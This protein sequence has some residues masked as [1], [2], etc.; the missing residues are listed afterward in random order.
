M[1]AET[2]LLLD[3]IRGLRLE[4]AKALDALRDTTTCTRE[5]VARLEVRVEALERTRPSRAKQMAV[6][7][8]LG[9][10]ISTIIFELSKHLGG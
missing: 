7:A 4:A 3:E 8:S 1:T 10:A 5:T 2:Q 6:P 9:V